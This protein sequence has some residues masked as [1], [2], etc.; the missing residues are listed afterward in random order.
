[1]TIERHEQVE[2]T[3]DRLREEF[4][5]T[6]RELDRRRHRAMD[7]RTLV[8]DNR[9]VLLAAGAGLAALV[10]VVVGVTVAL[11][12]TRRTRMDRRRLEG[13]RR[14]WENPDRLATRAEDMPRP[15]GILLNLLKVAVVAAGSQ[16]I[17]R[18]V[19]RSLPSRV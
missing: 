7:V 4:L 19:Q 11:T 18:T 12:R 17:R 13:F 9:R 10:I 5:I 16:I 1:M 6:L 2:R 3:A 8:R 15:L 14:A